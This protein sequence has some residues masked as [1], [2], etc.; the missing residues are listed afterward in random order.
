MYRSI[1]QLSQAKVMKK[2]AILA[3]AL[4]LVLMTFLILSTK[5]SQ[6]SSNQAQHDQT[7]LNIP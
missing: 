2:N 7:S 4:F 6:G 1:N 5:P 3:F